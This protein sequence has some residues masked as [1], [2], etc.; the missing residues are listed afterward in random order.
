M[1]K[2]TLSTPMR[3]TTSCV[4]RA[5]TLPYA[6]F[7]SYEAVLSKKMERRLH[8]APARP[9]AKALEVDR[10]RE[11]HRFDHKGPPTGIKGRKKI[12]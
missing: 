12:R 8:G 3:P 5:L 7:L 4:F 9:K 11:W 2:S 10:E 6:P 1:P